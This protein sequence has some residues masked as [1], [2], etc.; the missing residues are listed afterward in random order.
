L[1][2][3][4]AGVIE[5]SL[6]VMNTPWPALVLL[7]LTGLVVGSFLNLVIYRVPRD[8][9]ILMHDSRCPHCQTMIKRR[10]TVPVLGWLALRGKCASCHATIGSRYPLVE[11][12]TAV[13]FVAITLRFG[14]SS[15]LPAFLYLAA[16]GVAVAAI[17]VDFRRLPDS[18]VLPSYVV[19][20]LLL[21]PAGAAQGDLWPAERA[22]IAMALLCAFY[23]T[24]AIVYPGAMRFGDA[25]LAGLLGLYLGWLSWGAVLIAAIG[26]AGIIAVRGAIVRNNSS[27]APRVAAVAPCLVAAAVLA[28]FVAVPLSGWYTTV[29]HVA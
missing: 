13:L 18:I 2:T 6:R 15:E 16:F 3:H 1:G 21:M 26:G 24:L 10:H 19:C 12:G 7:G 17:D 25:K 23:F 9:S 8:E 11:L 22:V 29:L 28:L 27:S 4:R 14:M 5:G 20:V